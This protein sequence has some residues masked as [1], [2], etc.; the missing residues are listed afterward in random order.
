MAGA[1]RSRTNG[2][3]APAGGREGTRRRTPM[4]PQPHGS[5]LRREYRAVTIPWTRQERPVRQQVSWLVGHRAMHGLPRP[6][7]GD[8]SGPVAASPKRS[9]VHRARHLQLQ[10]QLRIK[11]ETRPH[12]IPSRPVSGH[13]R[14]HGARPR[15][16]SDRADNRN[17]RERLDGARD[18]RGRTMTCLRHRISA[19]GGFERRWPIDPN[20]P[21]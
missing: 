17:R 6:P 16:R 4:R 10:G 19:C 9:D 5:S 12:R 13:R 15:S 2:R 11:A 21:A 18:A 20:E 3:R 8:A 7:H 1:C 14:D